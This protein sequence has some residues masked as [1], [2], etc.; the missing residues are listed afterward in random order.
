MLAP[1]AAAPE[2]AG[3]TTAP[4]TLAAGNEMHGVS[5]IP[6]QCVAV[7]ASVVH[8][9][10]EA[11]TLSLGQWDSDALPNGAYSYRN[12]T[13]V[14]CPV[15]DTCI[16]VGV[17]GVNG[18]D[19]GEGF[20]E[21][22][23]AGA[24]H[25]MALPYG[26]PGLYSISCVSTTWCMADG[27]ESL[28]QATRTVALQWNGTTWNT[29]TAPITSLTSPS[30]WLDAVSCSSINFCMEVGYSADGT[31]LAEAWNG[32]AWKVTTP[33]PVY[34]CMNYDQLDAISCTSANFCL[35][36]GGG[37]GA[38]GTSGSIAMSWT[39]SNWTNVSNMSPALYFAVLSGVSCTRA[40]SCLTVGAVSPADAEMFLPYAAVGRWNG[41]SLTAVGGAP[42]GRES[43]L[44]GVSCTRAN[45]CAAVGTFTR[46]TGRVQP[47]VERWN[48]VTVN[49]MWAPGR[50]LTTPSAGV[51]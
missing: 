12:L 38:G 45:W 10:P 16:G 35:A 46:R 2:S 8:Q 27:S 36:V 21:Q 47:L 14:S 3:A 31:S 51:S 33:K 15:V 32:A 24:W 11:W 20:A 1:L 22:L 39:G 29:V 17:T 19:S 50:P 28:G 41:A 43:S 44:G 4:Q 42:V 5:C 13:S 49:R 30:P 7:G 25:R 23:A 18:Y 9:R 40:T 6:G 26:A 34:V 48:G 37:Y